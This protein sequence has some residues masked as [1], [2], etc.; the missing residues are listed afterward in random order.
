MIKYVQRNN[1]RYLSTIRSSKPSVYSAQ[2]VVLKTISLF[3]TF[4]S[5][6]SSEQSVVH[7]DDVLLDALVVFGEEG[8]GVLQVGVALVAFGGIETVGGESGW[9]HAVLATARGHGT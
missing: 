2:S 8:A 9:Q 7:V 1:I 3:S 5:S 4:R 6:K